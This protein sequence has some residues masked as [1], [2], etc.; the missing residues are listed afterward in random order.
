MVQDPV[1]GASLDPSLRAIVV[2]FVK[3]QSTSEV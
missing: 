1:L 3:P 2:V